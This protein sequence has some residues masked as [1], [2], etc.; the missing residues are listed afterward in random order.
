MSLL[1]AILSGAAEGPPGPP[2]DQG[3]VEEALA[4]NVDAPDAGLKLFHDPS[5]GLLWKHA[6]GRAQPV[7]NEP[8]LHLAR[9]VLVGELL[10]VDT[11]EGA[12]HRCVDHA[13]TLP[14]SATIDVPGGDWLLTEQLTLNGRGYNSPIPL[15]RGQGP[16]V[17]RIRWADGYT[18]TRIFIDGYQGVNDFATKAALYGGVVNMTIYHPLDMGQG[19]G[20]YVRQA[21]YVAFNNL[22]IRG[23]GHHSNNGIDEGVGMWLDGNRPGFDNLQHLILDNLDIGGCTTGLRTRSL[24]Q[25]KMIGVRLNQ[26]RYCDMLLDCANM[27]EMRQGMC[28]SIGNSGIDTI[29][30]NPYYMNPFHPIRTWGDALHSGTGATSSASSGGY[31]TMTE[32]AGM[33]AADVGRQ[34]WLKDSPDPRERGA[35]EITAYI[36]PSS[37]V[38][39]KSNG[40]GTTGLSYSVHGNGGGNNI[41]IAGKIYH[42]GT[43]PAYARLGRAEGTN[44][45]YVFES[46]LIWGCEWFVIADGGA[47]IT[48]RDMIEEPDVGW[49]KA[50]MLNRLEVSGISDTPATAPAK[51]DLDSYTERNTYIPTP[52]G[53]YS[54]TPGSRQLIDL[55]A[56]YCV[57]IWDTR[58]G[59][60]AAGD[61]GSSTWVGQLNGSVFNAYSGVSG[62][63]PGD[64]PFLCSSNPDFGGLP[65]IGTRRDYRSR[66]MKATLAVPVPAGAYP[67]LFAVFGAPR[68]YVPA[69]WQPRG[70]SLY[71]S[72]YTRKIQLAFDDSSTP[73][74]GAQITFA[75]G[76]AGLTRPKPTT[77]RP[78][79]AL[80]QQHQDNSGAYGYVLYEG[81]HTNVV[82][83]G[84]FTEACD[85][86]MTGVSLSGVQQYGDDF[87]NISEVAVIAVLKRPLPP[88]VAKAV[89]ELAHALWGPQVQQFVIPTVTQTSG[90]A[91]EMQIN[92]TV[93]VDITAGSLTLP[94]PAGHRR[95]DWVR[96][97]VRGAASGHTLT[98]DPNGSETID[99]AATLV[100]STDNAWCYL[101]SDGTNWMVLG[102]G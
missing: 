85:K 33:S 88:G 68:G 86:P 79:I 32:L 43:I 52:V 80:A 96:F 95:G 60:A 7:A 93:P 13:N 34:I 70:P 4:A 83:A 24:T 63:V 56:P 102:K 22:H 74:V 10:T 45:K 36:S 6:D 55:L 98:I 51:F 28:Q 12:L 26:N 39:R 89:F 77:T 76:N 100:L 48:I 61:G 46:M 23:L 8:V 82:S 78:V 99:G 42:E 91:Q 20:I 90:Y 11:F 30:L 53:T 44:D 1:D 15:L 62:G 81:N 31:V 2:G 5:F 16:H 25:P 64:R 54:S 58:Y 59:V 9:F 50:K 37:V 87:A 101:Q 3:A 19:V 35:F 38:I 66:S 18:G 72:D 47:S 49:V 71:S 97:K 27:F 41:T 29:S 17:T 69:N 67:G 94:L 75:Q 92:C 14:R 84:G 40:D 57:E 73:D 65:T 21:M